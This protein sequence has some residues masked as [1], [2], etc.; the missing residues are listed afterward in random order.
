[1]RYSFTQNV[2][3]ANTFSH[4]QKFPSL[5]VKTA[6]L[7]IS[8]QFPVSLYFY[9]WGQSLEFSLGKLTLSEFL[10]HTK[11]NKVVEAKAWLWY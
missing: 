7:I 1:M 3:A 11:K 5:P 10:C 9:F 8:P 6:R 4:V 2:T